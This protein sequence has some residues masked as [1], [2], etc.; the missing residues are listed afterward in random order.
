MDKSKPVI[1]AVA[2]ILRDS[3][4]RVLV[5]LRQNHVPQGGFWEFPGG[6]LEQ[7]ETAFQ[8]LSRELWEEIGV[9]V[10]LAHMRSIAE[11]AYE[12]RIVILETWEVSEFVGTPVGK[13]GQKIEWVALTEL[14]GRAFLP[15]NKATISS[16]TA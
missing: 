15:A 5:S 3:I 13:E 2:G 7:G 14:S 16:L 4:G 9:T 8:A 6:K 12:D 10:K 11:H 1:H